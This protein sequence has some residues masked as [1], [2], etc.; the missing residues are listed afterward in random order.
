MSI[1]LF[2]EQPKFKLTISGSDATKVAAVL[3]IL[4]PG[5]SGGRPGIMAPMMSWIA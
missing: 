2:G 3:R 4:T 5:S 1:T